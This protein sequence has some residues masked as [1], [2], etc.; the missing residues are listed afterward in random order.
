MDERLETDP[1]DLLEIA[2]T[3]D[4]VDDMQNP[5]GATIIEIS[6]RKELLRTLSWT[7]RAGL[8]VPIMMP[9]RSAAS[10]CKKSDLYQGAAVVE[11]E[12]CI[13]EFCLV[14]GVIASLPQSAMTSE[15]QGQRLP[16]SAAMMARHCRMTKLVHKA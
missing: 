5:I 12:T 3:G 14:S 9:R 1:A 16:R 11:A 7:A 8:A 6:L 10:T 4:A 13:S 15:Q 2:R